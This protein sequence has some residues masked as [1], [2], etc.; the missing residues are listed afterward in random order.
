M[1]YF[2]SLETHIWVEREKKVSCFKK[3]ETARV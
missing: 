1:N 2:V 3:Q